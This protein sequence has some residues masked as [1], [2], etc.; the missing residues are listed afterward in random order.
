MRGVRY[1]R[2]EASG[3]RPAGVLTAAF[4]GGA[5]VGALVW[6]T[7][8][9]RSRRDLFDPRPLRRLAAL[10]HLAG[11]PGLDTTRLLEDY[12]NWESRPSLRRRGER[13]LRQMKLYLD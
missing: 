12:V 7:Q 1:R 10:G 8:M 4:V 9:K 11:Q 2:R 6:S 13:L 5:V 3:W